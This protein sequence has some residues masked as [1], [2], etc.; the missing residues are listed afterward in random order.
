MTFE[1]WSNLWDKVFVVCKMRKD[2]RALLAHTLQYK[3][4]WNRGK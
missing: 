1:E 2:F 4:E 3:L